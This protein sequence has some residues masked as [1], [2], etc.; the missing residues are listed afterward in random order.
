MRTYDIKRETERET[1]RKT[2]EKLLWKKLQT[3][4]LHCH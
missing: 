1:E 4:Y 3:V 2:A